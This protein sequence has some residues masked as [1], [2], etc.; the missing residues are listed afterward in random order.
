MIENLA[1]RIRAKWV[2]EITEGFLLNNFLGPGDPR[3]FSFSVHE[4]STAA[5]LAH[6][7]LLGSV[8][9]MRLRDVDLAKVPAEHLASLASCVT[10]LV[11]IWN[12]S[13][14]DLTSILDRSKSKW[15]Q[16]NSQNLSTA[17]T[18][19]LVRA[20][21]SVEKVALGHYGKMTLDIH[22]LAT[23][24]GQGKCR[25]VRFW[26]TTARWYRED[27]RRW[28]QRISWRVTKD[29]SNAYVITKKLL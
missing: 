8:R 18:R 9:G 27:V 23:Y 2:G 11:D 20:M 5:S 22:T 6:H 4:I 1:E 13:N 15:I 24:N 17:E 3:A 7:G 14:T 28:V 26:H 29:D 12:V 25:E 16:I 21:A 10:E 19:A